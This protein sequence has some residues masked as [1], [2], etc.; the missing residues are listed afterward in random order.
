MVEMSCNTTTQCILP[1][2]ALTNI[3]CDD[4]SYGLTGIENC[5]AE[6]FAFENCQCA[7]ENYTLSSEGAKYWCQGNNRW[8]PD[9]TILQC[10]A[11]CEP[12][13]GSDVIVQDANGNTASSTVT[14][15]GNVVY[16]D[17]PLGYYGIGTQIVTCTDGS[18]DAPDLF[19]CFEIE[20]FTYPTTQPTTPTPT[21]LTTLQDMTSTF[22]PDI[23]SQP[24]STVIA[25]TELPSSSDTVSTNT[26]G[27]STD[28]ITTGLPDISTSGT[29]STSMPDISTNI[30]E[31]TTT[32]MV[33]SSTVE[34]STTFSLQSTVSEVTTPFNDVST[35]PGLS[36]EDVKSTF[37]TDLTTSGTVG[38]TKTYTDVI[39]T[40][41]PDISTSDTLSTS[42]PDIS[43]NTGEITT[44]LTVDSSTVEGSTTF[45]LQSTGSEVTTPFNDVFTM[46]GFTTDDMKTTL[47]TD[48]TTSGTVGTTK[49]YTDVITTVLPDISTS[50]TLSTSMPDISTN[51]GE[52]TTTLMVDSSTVE[53]ST[54]FSLQSTGSEVTTFF[55]DVFTMTGLT[56]DDM[57]TTLL[58]DLTTSDHVSTII[59]DETSTVVTDSTTRKVTTT[60]TDTSASDN[61]ITTDLD[62]INTVTTSTTDLKTDGVSSTLQ[63]TASR[64]L[65][66]TPDTT[67]SVSTT[68][69][70]TT[71]V[72]AVSTTVTS[73]TDVTTATTAASTTITNAGTT[74]T[75]APSPTTTA[76]IT[77]EFPMKVDTNVE[78]SP[79]QFQY[80]PESEI[81]FSCPEGY[82]LD[83]PLK[84]TCTTTGIWDPNNPTP[85][86]EENPCERPEFPDDSNIQ[87]VPDKSQYNH[88]ESVTFNCETGYSL[89]GPGELTCQT[90]TFG[91]ELPSCL[92][93]AKLEI[94]TCYIYNVSEE[95]TVTQQ[96]Y[97]YVV[98]ES[99]SL[100][101]NDPTK[102]L[103]LTNDTVT[104]EGGN[105]WS[106]PSDV[107]CIE[108]GANTAVQQCSGKTNSVCDRETSICACP[109]GE[110]YINGECIVKESVL[111]TVSLNGNYSSN[112][113]DEESSEFQNLQTD[114]CLAFE[115]ALTRRYTNV[116]RG[117]VNCYIQSFA[118]GSIITEVVTE[119]DASENVTPEDV[120]NILVVEL[121]RQSASENNYTL[122]GLSLNFTL[123]YQIESKVIV[124]GTNP[125]DDD[126]NNVCHPDLGMCN[127]INGSLYNCSCKSDFYDNYGIL[128][129][130]QPGIYCFDVDK[131]RY[132]LITGL[133]IAIPLFVIICIMFSVAICI[134]ICTKRREEQ[135]KMRINR[136][137]E[138]TTVIGTGD[139]SLRKN[140][141]HANANDVD[142]SDEIDGTSTRI[143]AIASTIEHMGE[144][145]PI[146]RASMISEPPVS[147][148]GFQTHFD[149]REVVENGA[150]YR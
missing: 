133:G 145:K 82:N 12:N 60:L 73:S 149:Q 68:T 51:T 72:P 40:V 23:T 91:T 10:F 53:G 81:T 9:I 65:T 143:K 110:E 28:V 108:C 112:L 79:Y 120:T 19:S 11:P 83:G 93:D 33:D 109:P 87:L 13:I 42:M 35:M 140:G 103:S 124:D 59:A 128:G 95:V 39:T 43:T 27:M 148:N 100:Q 26:I 24:P 44:T 111:T 146:P 55:D 88:D 78:V 21:L 71:A 36:T 5:Y 117:F 47:L 142:I 106:L 96:K 18:W 132:G 29:L 61:L 101:C 135:R 30:G 37:L 80:D 41:L 130:S 102:V 49:T 8:S 84:A 66:T 113:T 70:S 107:T 67:S 98:G 119:Y 90:G 52:I 6:Y 2:T 99:V 56:T 14:L 69:T 138:M 134:P 123:G 122:P 89:V 48:L 115:D 25:S 94:S 97:K 1:D 32:L 4:N 116:Q 45:S 16:Y 141:Y 58:T 139:Y 74:K 64:V 62:I 38:T 105:I 144:P 46:T 34:G 76:K 31:I 121:E 137:L 147:S 17:C 114:V 127:Q 150:N 50:D 86:C 57:K 126:A 75:N 22:L 136:D 85:T 63:S 131:P 129:V 125:C 7:M 54:T 15:H 104:C 20:N 92:E 118:D 3:N 77:C